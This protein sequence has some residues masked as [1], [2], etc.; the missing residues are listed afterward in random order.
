MDKS[1]SSP[2]FFSN[3][4]CSGVLLVL[5]FVVIFAISGPFEYGSKLPKPTLWVTGLLLLGTGVAFW[6]LGQAIKAQDNRKLLF[7][8]V[9]VSVSLRLIGLFTCPILEID[10]YR[11][12]WDGKVVAQGVS[13]YQYSPGQILKHGED[14]GSQLVKGLPDDSDLEK[15]IDL[16]VA[17]QSNNTIVSRIHFSEYSTIYPPISQVV[18]GTTMKWFPA[19]ASVVAHIFSIKAI[20]VSFDLMILA[21]ILWLLNHLKIHTGWSIAYAWNPLVLKEISN[22][23]HLDSIA[24]FFLILSICLLAKW[25]AQKQPNSIPWLPALSGISLGL[26]VGAKLFPIVLFPALFVTAARVSWSRALLFGVAFAVAAGLS[27]YPMYRSINQTSQDLTAQRTQQNV[28]TA[29]IE[30]SPSAVTEDNPRQTS[31]AE[32]SKKEGLTSFL[33]KWRMNDVIFSGIYLNLKTTSVA[34]SDLPWYVITT[35]EFRRWAYEQWERLSPDSDNPAFSMTRVLTLGPFV[36]FYLWQLVAIYFARPATE[37]TADGRIQK[38]PEGI[39]FNRL[40]WILVIFLFLQPTVNPWYWV[41]VAPLTVL[42]KNRG[43]ILAG[44]LLLLYYS[45]FWFESL[46]DSFEIA[47]YSG[48]GLF[49]HGI[50]WIEFAAVVG[51]I[52]MTGAYKKTVGNK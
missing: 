37:T 1:N 26:G 48:V 49:D 8:V 24:A 5:A 14:S 34:K 6:G 15:L 12:L 2:N 40:V 3:V 10:Y 33:S 22:G 35:A 11:Y 23:G 17:S 25:L 38:S 32:N 30:A 31:Q 19:S 36:L 46:P 41:W 39:E 27:F 13:P 51:V 29:T 18:F 43:W 42:T 20:L 50:A 9:L 47:G 28:S 21:V 4:C 16:S 52:A 7:T 44:G 45:R